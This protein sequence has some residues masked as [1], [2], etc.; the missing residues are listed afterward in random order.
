MRSSAKAE[1]RAM[2]NIVNEV[3]WLRWLFL[4]LTVFRACP[5][6]LYFDNQ[7][8]LHITQNSIYHERTKYVE[9]ADYFVRE[10][11]Q[12]QERWTTILFVRVQYPTLQD[13]YIISV[14]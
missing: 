3:I 14:G 4:D 8:E 5:T 10:R 2:A 9:M 7:T 11:V 1:Y 6:P 13:I 12:S